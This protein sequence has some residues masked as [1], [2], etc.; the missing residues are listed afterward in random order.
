MLT[1]CFGLL[2]ILVLSRW[3]EMYDKSGG[4]NQFTVFLND[5]SDTEPPSVDWCLFRNW[6]FPTGKC[7]KVFVDVSMFWI[8]VS[9][10]SIAG[11]S[12]VCGFAVGRISQASAHSRIGFASRG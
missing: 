4:F 2:G 1:V 6:D 3:V 9:L 7:E 8:G 5:L 10:L 12:A 11:L